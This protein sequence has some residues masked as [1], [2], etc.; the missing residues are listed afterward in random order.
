MR[1]QASPDLCARFKL[2]CEQLRACLQKLL[3]TYIDLGRYQILSI[4]PELFFERRGTSL[5]MRPM[6]GTMPRGRW[7]EEDEKKATELSTCEKNRAENLMIVDLIRSDLGKI[8]TLG[9]VQV[10]S[11]FEVERYESLWQMTSLIESTARPGTSLT[12]IFCALYPSGS[13]TG[14]PKV[15]TMEIIHTLE[16]FPRLVYTGA[17]GFIRPDGNC[18]FN[19]AIRTIVLDT[20]SG[21][22]TF[23]VG[24]GIT[25]DSAARN[26]YEECVLKT[27]FLNNRRQTFQLLESILLDSGKFFLLDRHIDRLKSSARYFGYALNEASLRSKLDRLCET[28]AVGSWKV[29]LLIAKNGQI[30]IEPHEITTAPDKIYRV[31]LAMNPIASQD[32]FIFHKTTS[33]AFYEHELRSRPDCNDIIFWNE[34]N[35]ITES[36]TANLVLVENGQRGTPLRSS[37]LLAG[38]YRDELLSKGEIQERIIYKDELRKANSFFLI[39]SVRTWIPAVLVD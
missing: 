32:P 35:E 27:Q 22:A 37:G 2:A 34:R 12:D 26:E 14:A 20:Q 11:L 39:N 3:A 24:S 33:R 15:R 13:I 16:P 23:G 30:T 8:S 5:I 9:T 25:Y 36:S 31:T 17:I 6:K 38:T 4:S 21:I 18:I 29:R 10:T 7:K 1:T 28:H 19:V